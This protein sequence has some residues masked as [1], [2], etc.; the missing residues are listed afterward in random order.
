MTPQ[1]YAESPWLV[2]AT[3]LVASI[4]VARAVRVLVHEDFPPGRWVRNTWI[5]VT[6]GGSWS[7]IVTCH[8][9]AAPYLVAGSML[10]FGLGLWLWEP[11][12]WG[13][14]VVHLWAALSYAASWVVHHDEDGGS[15]E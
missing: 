1:L 2:L 11:L 9:C 5:A 7:D 14:W 12:L 6:K 15:A 10:W 8:W 13:W 4:G 3:V